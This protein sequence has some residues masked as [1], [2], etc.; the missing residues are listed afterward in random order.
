MVLDGFAGK[1]AVGFGGFVFEAQVLGDRGEGFALF[2]AGEEGGPELGGLGG[3][4]AAL[5][6]ALLVEEG[7]EGGDAIEEGIG[8]G[9]WGGFGLGG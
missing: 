4:G 3:A 7:L 2:A 1:F 8:W 9:G 5:A 6:V